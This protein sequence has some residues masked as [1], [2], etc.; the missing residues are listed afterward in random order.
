MTSDSQGSHPTVQ[1]EPSQQETFRIHISLA[2]S[3][4]SFKPHCP[5]SSISVALLGTGSLSH[6]K[7]P[8]A[9]HLVHSHLPSG[10]HQLVTLPTTS[11]TSVPGA[12]LQPQLRA[13]GSP[14]QASTLHKP[15]Q[16]LPYT[17]PQSVL[18][19]RSLLQRLSPVPAP[20]SAGP[21]GGR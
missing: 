5:C 14:G 2:A 20:A 8:R 12:A 7:Q 17:R 10:H 6:R 18:P 4:S 13:E 1:R 15:P 3:L 9:P 19:T 21:C 16:L 11:P